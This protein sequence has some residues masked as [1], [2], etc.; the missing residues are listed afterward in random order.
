M[1]K[2][3]YWDLY[4]SDDPEGDYIARHEDDGDVIDREFELAYD[5]MWWGDDV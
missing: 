5:R 2:D 3:E 4:W 1:T